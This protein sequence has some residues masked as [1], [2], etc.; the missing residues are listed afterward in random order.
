MSGNIRTF[1]LGNGGFADV[2]EERMDEWMQR[3]DSRGIDFKTADVSADMQVGE[4]EAIKS[5]RQPV[6]LPE[7]RITA[8]SGGASGEWEEPEPS[9]W[10]RF[11]DTTGD[12]AQT[13]A[14]ALRGGIRGLTMGY[15]DKVE[16]GVRSALPGGGSY[17]EEF[18]DQNRMHDEAEARS[19]LGYN[20]GKTALG[21]PWDLGAAV[22]GAP[23]GIGGEIATSGALGALRGGGMSRSP[24][25]EGTLEDANRGGAEGGAWGLGGAALGKLIGGGSEALTGLAPKARASAL[26]HDGARARAMRESRGDEF[27]ENLP[28]AADDLGMTPEVPMDWRHPVDSLKKKLTFKSPGDYADEAEGLAAHHGE[29]KGQAVADATAQGV[30][31]PRDSML[32]GMRG[33]VGAQPTNLNK[34]PYARAMG[35]LEDMV[36]PGSPSPGAPQQLGAG[37]L[38]KLKMDFAAGG[39]PPDGAIQRPSDAV[40]ARAQR[41]AASVARNQLGGAIDEMALPETALQYHDGLDNASKANSIEGMAR[42]KQRDLDTQNPF[43]L[44]NV[45]RTLGGVAGGASIGGALGGVPGAVLGG[46]G[47]FVGNKAAQNYGADAAADFLRSGPAARHPSTP[48]GRYDPASGAFEALPFGTPGGGVRDAAVLGTMG[49]A[50]G[51]APGGVAGAALGALG[52]PGVRAGAGAGQATTSSRDRGFEDM[53][54]ESPSDSIG[55]GRGYMLPEVAKDAALNNPQLLGPYAEE[56][57]RAAQ[58]GDDGA[59]TQLLQALQDE[60]E[61]FRTTILPRLR[62]QTRG[63]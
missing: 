51:G 55:K 31:A 53:V 29:L 17:D 63:D 60:D 19:P 23:G 39:Y 27:V 28:Q 1:K 18:A 16:A 9:I 22:L 56:F 11:K 49:A 46:V 21:A 24:T 32:A 61:S 30:S 10:Q 54:G 3:M 5:Q 44:P 2:P 14:D 12:A 45:G 43:S 36:P 4:P 20:L 38:D 26:G 7:M 33:H 37:E 48:G 25:L 15:G 50:V 47:G 40:R 42:G 58:S 35:Q 41:D 57:Q 52:A 34:K 59:I 8:G 6:E 13:S 62:Q